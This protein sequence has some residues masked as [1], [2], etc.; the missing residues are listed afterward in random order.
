VGPAPDTWT[1]QPMLKLAA[2]AEPQPVQVIVQFENDWSLE[3][4]TGKY[5][6]PWT[7][8]KVEALNLQEQPN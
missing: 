4:Q 6:R 3:Q 7:P 2:R 8:H 1:A 5:I